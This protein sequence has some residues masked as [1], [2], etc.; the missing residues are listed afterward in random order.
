MKHFVATEKPITV[1]IITMI[2]GTTV[3]VTITKILL[4]S[5]VVSVYFCSA[6]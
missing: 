3:E 4:S 6:K 2:T 1:I 5:D